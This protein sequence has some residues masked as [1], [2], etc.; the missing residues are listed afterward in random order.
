VGSLKVWTMK[1]RWGDQGC[2]AMTVR[3]ILGV[4][5][6]NFSLAQPLR[7]DAQYGQGIG[8]CLS[9]NDIDEGSEENL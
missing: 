9:R 3:A 1:V 2:L 5:H 7:F 8:I 6:S 4:E